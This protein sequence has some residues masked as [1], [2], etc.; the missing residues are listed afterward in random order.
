MSQQTLVL[1]T[2]PPSRFRIKL[3]PSSGLQFR[4][5]ASQAS[6]TQVDKDGQTYVI[7]SN[8]KKYRFTSEKIGSNLQ[9]RAD[10]RRDSTHSTH[11]RARVVRRRIQSLHRPLDAVQPETVGLRLIPSLSIQEFVESA[12]VVGVAASDAL[13]IFLEPKRVRALLANVKD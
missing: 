1:I 2:T 10:C 7:V 5:F 6:C 13:T 3:N 11:P 12:V 8:R 4:F 9:S